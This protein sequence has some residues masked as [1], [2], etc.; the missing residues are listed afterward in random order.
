MVAGNARIVN[1][2]GVIQSAANVN[3]WRLKWKHFHTLDD[4]EGVFWHGI[5]FPA[6]FFWIGRCVLC[7]FHG[8]LNL[9]GCQHVYSFRRK[10]GVHINHDN[11]W[12]LKPQAS[13]LR[14]SSDNPNERFL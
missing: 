9:M 14:G 8:T 2:E 6:V 10:T 12:K 3:Y 1:H 4:Q 13:I 5:I 11:G 7:V